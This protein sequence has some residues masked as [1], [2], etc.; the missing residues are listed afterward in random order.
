MNTYIHAHI[1]RDSERVTLFSSDGH[2]I[3]EFALGKL[4]PNILRREALQDH[5][6]AMYGDDLDKS[7]IGGVIY[8]EQN[9]GA[10]WTRADSRLSIY[11]QHE[12]GIKMHWS[13]TNGATLDTTDLHD[14]QAV[15]AYQ[16]MRLDW[17]QVINRLKESW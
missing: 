2:M 13:G 6:D 11:Q 17:R 9:V 10:E 14:I 3:E 15:A 16:L 8:G 1:D 5:I 4:N 7:K 12:N